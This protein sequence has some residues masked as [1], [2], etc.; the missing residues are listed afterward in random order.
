MWCV[1]VFVCFS[2]C[3]TQ[4]MALVL[5]SGGGRECGYSDHH[6]ER[7]DRQKTCRVMRQAGVCVRERVCVSATERIRE[8]YER[9]NNIYSV[10]EWVTWF[11]EEFLI[12]SWVWFD[13]H[14]SCVS[15]PDL[16]SVRYRKILLMVPGRIKKQG[17]KR[18][19]RDRG[20][21]KDRWRRSSMYSMSANV[22]TKLSVPVFSFLQTVWT[23][24]VSLTWTAE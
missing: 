3:Y 13:G 18:Q 10:S 5:V 6:W 22:E 21:G 7:A 9:R 17:W 19:G 4:L 16:L 8:F 12:N 1:N 20:N 11:K 15:W 14:C 24:P 2:M 23:V